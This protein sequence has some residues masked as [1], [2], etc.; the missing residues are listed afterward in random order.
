[1]TM[2][3][4][5]PVKCPICENEIEIYVLA[6]TNTSGFPDL[7]LRPPEMERSTMNTW[8]HECPHCGYAASDFEKT[9]EVSRDFISGEAYRKCDGHEFINPLSK[10]FYHG[11]M[12]S[13]DDKE[14][15]NF[16]L[17]CAWTCDDADDDENA[18]SIRK[19]SLKYLDLLE[20]NDNISLL[21][22]D[23]LRRSNQFDAVI[24]GYSSASYPEEIHNQISA[25]Q[26]EKAVQKDSACYTIEDVLKMK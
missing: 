15:F 21:K 17:Y 14:R 3:F 5:E 7:D 13:E 1:M 11:Y 26:V 8:M 12:I 23:I 9:P 16:L 18:V 2:I 20:L 25:F 6:S 19:K 10:R 22:A 24:E 4:P